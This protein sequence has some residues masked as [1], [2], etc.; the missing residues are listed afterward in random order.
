MEKFKMFFAKTTRASVAAIFIS[1][2]CIANV[3]SGGGLTGAVMFSVGLIGVLV[4]ESDLYTGKIAYIKK[5]MIPNLIIMLAVNILVAFL[6]G[7]IYFAFGSVNVSAVATVKLAKPLYTVFVDALIC[8]ALIYAA[9]EGWKRTRQ[10]LSVVFPVATFV[11]SGAEHCVADAF[12][13]AGSGAYAW[14]VLLIIVLGNSIG[15]V[16]VHKLVAFGAAKLADTAE[17]QPKQ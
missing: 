2:A 8:G 3:A 12:Y 6:F 14:L 13:F 1:I 9:V 4:L 15:S 5:S 16:I 17:K 10:I 7:K 11:V